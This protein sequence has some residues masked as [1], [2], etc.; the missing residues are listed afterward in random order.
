MGRPK[1]LLPLGDKPVIR[2]CLDAIIAAGI[3]DIVVVAGAQNANIS[4]VL[5]NTPARMVVNEEPNSQMADSVRIGLNA[6][7][8]VF[9]GVLV[10][11]SDHPLVSTETFKAVISRH[12]EEPDRIIIPACR[13]KRG[14]PTLFPRGI[15]GELFSAATLLD[16]IKKDDG[17]V[18][19]LEVS[20]EGIVL[21]MNTEGDYRRA[22]EKVSMGK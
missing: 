16:I 22:C 7:E 2:H 1:Q 15:I 17:R 18:R 4:E 11:L 5:R 6:L 10:C 8:D 3:R 9:S 21:N 12:Y 14:H 20:D 19:V 13:G